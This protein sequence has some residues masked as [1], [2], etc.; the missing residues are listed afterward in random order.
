MNGT[1][2]LLEVGATC[3]ALYA[4]AVVVHV[5]VLRSLRWRQRELLREPL[6]TTYTGLDLFLLVLLLLMLLGEI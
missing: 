6:L 2:L 3:L 5:V 1:V 4:L